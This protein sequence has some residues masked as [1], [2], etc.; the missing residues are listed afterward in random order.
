MKKWLRYY[1]ISAAALIGVATL[2]LS[3]CY[4]IGQVVG[5]GPIIEKNYDYKDFNG[6]EI[7]ST[8][9]VDVTHSDT[10][11]ITVSTQE[12]IINHVDVRLS[13]NTLIIRLKPGSY[14]YADLRA[15]VTLPELTKLV[16]SGAS[17]AEVT[18]FISAK[19]LDMVVSGASQLNIDIEAGETSVEGS[20]ASRLNGKLKALDSD[21]EVSGASRCELEGSGNS[22]DL[23]VSGASQASLTNFPVKN[24][25][26]NVSGASRSLVNISGT[27]NVEVSGASTV[28][29]F[30]NPSLGKVSVT[31]ASTLRNK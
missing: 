21:F 15:K 2:L 27:L 25:T 17:R 6:I 7:S 8:F 24:A 20:G 29:Y 31:G 5:A 19:N 26:L 3:G 13:G 22:I 4:T 12:N 9:N 23:G 18:G 1:V 28:E 16:I 14:T 11:S 10:F 30:G